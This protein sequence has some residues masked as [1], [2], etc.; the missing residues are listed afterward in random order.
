MDANVLKSYLV[1][2]GFSVN[3]DEFNKFNSALSNAT[4]QV[5]QYTKEMSKH[6]IQAS[7]E[8]VGALASVTTA[9]VAMVD[10]VVQAD[11]KYQN[12]ALTMHMTVE[13]TREMDMALKAMGTT[14]EAVAWN[15]EQRQQYFSL[16][17]QQRQ[18]SVGAGGETAFK[19]ARNVRF[20]F[21]RMKL[22]A[23]YSL[24]W[25]SYM[26]IEKLGGPLGSV[27]DKLKDFNDY[28]A[29]NM[30]QIT[31]KIANWII[32]TVNL[33]KTIIHYSQAAIGIFEKLWE[34]MNKGEK[35][36]SGLGAVITAFFVMGPLMKARIVVTSLLLALDDLYAYMDGRKSSNELAP[37]WRELLRNMDDNKTIMKQIKELFESLVSIA[38]D[39]IKTLVSSGA[40]LEIAKMFLDIGKAVSSLGKG[41]WNVI[42][43]V[44]E[45]FGIKPHGFIDFITEA[46]R[47]FA[48]M[49]RAIA[50]IF[51]MIGLVAQGKF[52]AAAE[53]GREFMKDYQQHASHVGQYNAGGSSV[54]SNHFGM[55]VAHASSASSVNPLFN[56]K[57]NAMGETSNNLGMDTNFSTGNNSSSS[58][59]QGITGDELSK[60]MQNIG[61]VESGGD[62]NSPPH[63]DEGY[64]NMG[65]KYQIL[66]N[67]WPSWAQAA[68]LSPDAPYSAA[69]QEI[70]ARHKM[71]ELYQQYRD[72]NQVAAAW[73]GGGGGAESYAKYGSSSYEAGYVNKV[74]GGGSGSGG[75][76]NSSGFAQGAQNYN[77]MTSSG[78]YQNLGGGNYIAHTTI[79]D[80]AVTVTKANA[81]ENDVYFATLKA[82]QDATSKQT[83]RQINEFQNIMP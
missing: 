59:A 74:M 19:D 39:F 26:L 64:W 83:A 82:M 36:L 80:V 63:M 12:M 33:F 70:V 20:E 55:S 8:I 53:R 21:V 13:A 51:D 25:I 30:P 34:S 32:M 54:G 78:A 29:T 65:G 44:N 38:K 15:P 66:A 41:L 11:I 40:L 7:T 60:F 6:F 47:E 67:N 73:N 62:Y 52:S 71:T 1:S 31:D 77:A 69:N 2:L 46:V 68:G 5:G 35:H 43:L 4:H 28:I 81:N 48:Y 10:K 18:M 42:N 23:E 37:I 49:G 24:M 56:T 14:I 75:G 16:I 45:L 72:W 17:A 27:K 3:N 76:S 50:G 9:T 57:L 79:G 61:R 22:E 58:N